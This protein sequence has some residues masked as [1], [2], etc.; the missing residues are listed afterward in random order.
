MKAID[1]LVK[2]VLPEDMHGMLHDYDD[3]SVN[4]FLVEVYKR[5]PDK[6]KDITH[7]L[8]TLG[9]RASYLQGE[10]IS[11]KDLLPVID[12][13][14]LYK[15]MDKEIGQAKVLYKGDED[16]FKKERERI[17]INYTDK[18][19]KDTLDQARANQNSI[20]MSVASGARG[21]AQ[22]IQAMLSTPA[23]FQDSEDNTIPY[24]IRHSY[25]EGVTPGEYAASSYGARKSVI[26]TK[27]LKFN[28]LVRMSDGSSKMIKDIIVGD[29]ILG[30]DKLG[31]TFPALVLNVF[32]HGI[33]PT[34]KA[35]FQERNTS[36][37][38]TVECSADHKFLHS[39][40]NTKPIDGT[41]VVLVKGLADLISYDISGENQCYDIEVGHESH[42]FVL[43]NSL[44]TSNSA[45]ALGGDYGKLLSQATANLVITEK[46]CGANNGVSY[47]LDDPVIRGRV[48]L[49]DTAGI[50]GGT[51]LERD[52]IAKLRKSG[53]KSITARSPL[54]CKADG[55][56]Q[57][58]AGRT[59]ENKLP[60]I[61][62]HLGI[63]S[64]QA[65]C[66][67]ERTLVMMSDGT[68]KQIQFLKP[69]DQVLGVNKDGSIS[70]TK[71][72]NLIDRGK[73]NCVRYSFSTVRGKTSS[74]TCTEDHK[75]IR[76]VY[77]KNKKLV[78]D[79]K[80]VPIKELEEDELGY[81]YLKGF[82]LPNKYKVSKSNGVNEPFAR[83]IGIMLGDGTIGSAKGTMLL[84]CPDD[85]LYK[86]TNSYL[87]NLGYKLSHRSEKSKGTCS[88]QMI[89]DTTEGSTNILV[90]NTLRNK[91]MTTKL[92]GTRCHDKFIPDEV[93]AWDME[94]V[95]AFI[96][97]MILTDGYVSLH[98]NKPTIGFTSICEKLV[99]DLANLI[100][101]RLFINNV[102]I[103]RSHRKR[104][105]LEWNE[106]ELKVRSQDSFLRLARFI[107]PY[108]IGHK[109]RKIDRAFDI[110]KGHPGVLGQSRIA[111]IDQVVP[112]GIRQTYDIHVDNKT[113]LFL[114][115]GFIQ[116]HNSE[117]VTQGALC[118]D[119]DT[120]VR[121]GD[122]SV[123]KIKDIQVGDSVMGSDKE[124]NA[125]PVKVNEVFNNG[126]RECYKYTFRKGSTHEYIDLIST[127]EHKILANVK[128]S[129]LIYRA[130]YEGKY[131][132][133][134]PESY[135]TQILPVGTQ[136]KDFA[137][138]L[139]NSITSSVELID[140][141]FALILGVLMGDGIRWNPEYNDQGI[142][143]SCA[144]QMLVDDLNGYLKPLGF[145]TYKAK[146]G[147]DYV[148][149]STGGT[150][151]GPGKPK[152]YNF[153]G[154]IVRLKSLLKQKILE[155][156]FGGK[157]C[158]EKT[159]PV[160]VW[161]WNDRSILDLIA[162]Y[163]ATDGS[164]YSP[165][166]QSNSK[167]ISFGS[168]SLAMMQDLKNLLE[169][170][171]CVRST[172]IYAPKDLDAHRNNLCHSFSISR[173]DQV[174]KLLQRVN[175][176]GI[177]KIRQTEFTEHITNVVSRHPE[178]FFRAKKYLEE[179]VGYRNTFDLEVDHESHLFVLANSLIVSNSTKH[180]SG[181]AS[182]KKVFGGFSILS[183]FVQ[184]P[185]AYQHKATVANRDGIVNEVKEAPQ[186]GHYIGVDGE[187]HYVP[188]GYDV[189][190]KPG[191]A[192]EAGD[193]MSDGI[194]DVRDVVKH[195]GLGEA[196]KYYSERMKQIYEDSGLPAEKRNLEVV[197]RGALNNV[198]LDDDIEDLDN[199]PDDVVDYNKAVRAYKPSNTT[200]V[201]PKEGIGQY[202]QKDHLH[203]TVGTKVT[204]KVAS[205]LKD[206]GV[207]KITVGE[208]KPPFTADMDRL[209]TAAHANPDWLASM[210]TSYLKK[211]LLEGA[212][213]G[214]ETNYLENKH[215]A[216]R[217]G[218]GVGFGEN[219]E[220]T[221]KF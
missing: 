130:M 52:D 175:I 170:R 164:L 203:Y 31:T 215:W 75:I 65:L 46:D 47:D 205:Y 66:L 39:D 118:L 88:V 87:N 79:I 139:T 51:I 152:E 172:V 193:Q 167:I 127:P 149:S 101:H 98:D 60:R 189:M 105:N 192:V 3:K 206:N 219:I 218:Y 41:P 82:H 113:H 9:N 142:R 10:T 64:A 188:H 5:Y 29:Y 33:L 208:I 74:V 138:V 213:R 173:G 136:H 176:P 61:G 133:N 180:T 84:S 129:G 198:V 186:G 183:Q 89:R 121:M 110:I 17:W 147:F 8:G 28:E 97:G 70:T 200:D 20:G 221:G 199:L 30:V 48:L 95:A 122:F 71:V 68:K 190:V 92:W 177:K 212:Q 16:G 207:D 27:S 1:L 185:D 220:D 115:D 59:F 156:G 6:Y 210:S 32:D 69:G 174:L 57:L 159:L 120:E 19:R 72:L 58:C 15:Q 140:E 155:E 78:T 109:S 103:K 100:E 211:Q 42:L 126:E 67:D 168:T 216:P 131:R 202:L 55:L 73:Q 107:Q 154:K 76:A 158:H 21:K 40:D 90:S 161:K 150:G 112:A 135:K 119:E 187:Q 35:T 171:L 144:D 160:N 162:G 169:I 194:V 179:F 117:P 151:V 22:Q 182:G 12:T 85:D 81:R 141:P 94:S 217:I 197:S 50:P 106:Y 13:E 7:A 83:I 102:Y 196:R 163:I 214:A 45:T 26:A 132:W 63:T 146:R 111:T 116:V 23:L 184:A 56:C 134:S 99:D 43:H 153:N 124:G 4:N 54:T 34:F 181:Q 53:I 143:F 108:M 166:G 114:L 201:D 96:A 93:Y 91:F 137:S 157:Y 123:K 37:I 80:E 178:S 195:K 25:G 165:K 44:I 14:S 86:H 191:D 38:L 49:K 11:L 145:Y 24:F 148:I 104:D 36:N 2:S 204:P 77:D 209:R 125:F 128:N 18:I 62:E